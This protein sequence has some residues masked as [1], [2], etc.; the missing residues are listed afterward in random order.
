MREWKGTKGIFNLI[1]G[2]QN[3][4]YH[5]KKLK[6]FFFKTNN[7]LQNIT[8]LTKDGGI[9]PHENENNYWDVV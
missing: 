6:R 1:S 2:K 3:Q 8:Y 4:Q 9:D 5:C 7:S